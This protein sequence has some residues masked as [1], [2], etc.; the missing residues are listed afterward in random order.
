MVSAL[1]AALPTQAL[2]GPDLDGPL[3]DPTRPSGWQ[4]GRQ[5]TPDLRPRDAAGLH[6]QGIF[7]SRGRREA[8]ING[9]RVSIGDVIAG[10][11]VVTIEQRRVTLLIDGEAIELAT[12]MP[13][14]KSPANRGEGQIR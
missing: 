12:A 1:V 14:V 8:L 2:A 10:G 5:S 4:A 3:R 6:L 11:K 9:Q 13:A 7:R